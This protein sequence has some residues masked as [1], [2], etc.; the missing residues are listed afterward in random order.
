MGKTKTSNGPK[1]GP[2][3]KKD[4]SGFFGGMNDREIHQFVVSSLLRMPMTYL[5]LAGQRLRKVKIK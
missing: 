2:D 5:K 4:W 3:G 1:I